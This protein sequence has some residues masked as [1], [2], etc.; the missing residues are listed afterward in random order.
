MPYA[1]AQAGKDQQQARDATL[2]G[3]ARAM[4]QVVGDAFAPGIGGGAAGRRGCRGPRTRP[5]SR[6]N[7]SAL[8][9][10]QR[11]KANGRAGENSACC[12]SPPSA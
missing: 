6:T 10:H 5:P 8:A 7:P 2:A 3:Q 4:G 9:S 11:M 1:A 12:Q